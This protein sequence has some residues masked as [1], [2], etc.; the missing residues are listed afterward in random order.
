MHTCVN[1][2]CRKENT[3]TLLTWERV[4]PWSFYCN[5]VCVFPRNHFLLAPSLIITIPLFAGRVRNN[6]AVHHRR[7]Q[8]FSPQSENVSLFFGWFCCFARPSRTRSYIP[9]DPHSCHGVSYVHCWMYLP[10]HS[11]FPC[12][13]VV[14]SVCS[15]CCNS[16]RESS[17]RTPL[18]FSPILLFCVCMG[19]WCFFFTSVPS[20]A[21]ITE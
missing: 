15:F 19:I 12:F 9:H 14:L 13:A 21:L 8:F 20:F 18:A 11:H 6:I 4:S 5:R 2:G 17:R 16:S 1:L 7:Q 10:P 3:L